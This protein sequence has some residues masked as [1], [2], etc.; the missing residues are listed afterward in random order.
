MALRLGIDLDGVLADMHRELVRQAESLFGSVTIPAAGSDTSG[1]SSA[2]ADAAAAS[3]ILDVDPA[4]KSLKLTPKQ[5]RALWEHVGSI[6]NF[7]ESLSEIEPGFV[8]RLW[9]VAHER[10]W[11][12]IFLTKRP[13]S[14]GA[15]SQLQTQRWLAAAGFQHPCT[16]VVQGSRG[17]I[18][19]ALD[20]RYVVDD[21][22]EN[23][24]DVVMDSGARAVLVWRDAQPP[25][26]AVAE[27]KGIDIVRSMDECLSLL[28]DADDGANRGF[29]SKVKRF[30][31]GGASSSTR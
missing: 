25:T 28:V 24:L 27:W 10:G 23:C 13:P 12:I 1:H 29:L 15:P 20:L 30:L 18:A 4:A 22:P 7:W 16:Y 19:S 8:S 11:E 31:T 9:G 21:R 17:R 14:A 5:Q 26:N 3:P 6:E 2:S